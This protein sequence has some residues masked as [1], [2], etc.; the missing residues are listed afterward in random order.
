MN[1]VEYLRQ[2]QSDAE[3][4]ERVAEHV[5]PE[6]AKLFR[7]YR[8]GLAAA[9]A[10]QMTTMDSE[11]EVNRRAVRSTETQRIY[12]GKIRGIMKAQNVPLAKARV[13]YRKS[14]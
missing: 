11:S 2:R 3:T 9:L 12:W 6:N 13:L 8:L 1:S 14:Q 5:D 4:A 7:G 10:G